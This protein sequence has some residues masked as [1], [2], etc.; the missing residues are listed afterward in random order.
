LGNQ[1]EALTSTRTDSLKDLN[2]IRGE[3]SDLNN[4]AENQ[5]AGVIA[6]VTVPSND[7]DAVARTEK[8]VDALKKA[9]IVVL[10]GTLRAAKNLPDDISNVRYYYKS[11]DYLDEP[12]A[13]KVMQLLIQTG[14][15]SNKIR[16]SFVGKT[17]W[18][19]CPRKF[20]QVVLANSAFK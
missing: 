7:S 19:T 18:Q 16:I 6:E 8:Y 9:G 13:S 14:I 20:M 2:K 1:L 17:A 11:N 12:L 15:P 4:S 5:F 3:I 10:S